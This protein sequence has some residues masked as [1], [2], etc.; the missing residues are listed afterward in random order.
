VFHLLK[1]FDNFT[2]LPLTLSKVFQKTS[3]CQHYIQ[4]LDARRVHFVPIG[5]LDSHHSIMGSMIPRLVNGSNNQNKIITL[6][7]K[8]VKMCKKFIVIYYSHLQVWEYLHHAAIVE[9]CES[10]FPICLEQSALFWHQAVGYSVGKI[11]VFWK[12][13]DKVRGKIVKIKNI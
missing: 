12:T 2:I 10:N 13:F 7:I 6:H 1:Y 3:I 11:D 9:W 5:K 4:L 8:Y